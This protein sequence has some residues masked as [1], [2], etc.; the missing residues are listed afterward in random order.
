VIRGYST[1]TQSLARAVIDISSRPFFVCHLPFTRE[2]VGDC[3]CISYVF[4]SSLPAVSTEMVS[5]L[6][7][8]FAFEAG[9]TLHVDLIRGENNHHM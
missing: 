9:V 8:S 3:A 1:D 5:H 6:L 2:K 4:E 7:Q